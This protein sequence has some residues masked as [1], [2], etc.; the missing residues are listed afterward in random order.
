[1]TGSGLIFKPGFRVQRFGVPGS[2]VLGSGFSVQ[3]LGIR[4]QGSEFWVQSFRGYSILD[5]GFWNSDL[6]NRFALNH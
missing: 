5:F 4:V 6:R 2:E 1:M 3:C